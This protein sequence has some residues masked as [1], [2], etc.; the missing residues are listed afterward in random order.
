MP[1]RTGVILWRKLRSERALYLH[2]E[3]SLRSV[4]TVA[5]NSLIFLALPCS[6]VYGWIGA[7]PFVFGKGFFLLET[8]R[9]VETSESILYRRATE[10]VSIVKFRELQGCTADTERVSIVMYCELHGCTA[11][12]SC[13][14]DS[15]ESRSTGLENYRSLR[16]RNEFGDVW[17]LPASAKILQVCPIVDTRIPQ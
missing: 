11:D 2:L 14:L 4:A 9:T 10:R 15:L 6:P 5:L 7:L 16:E 13:A 17:T 12:R 3:T 1:F 8:L